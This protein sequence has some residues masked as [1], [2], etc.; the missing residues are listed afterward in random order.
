M[1]F[2]LEYWGWFLSVR[3]HQVS[4]ETWCFCSL[5]NFAFPIDKMLRL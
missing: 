1:R 3:K 5:L 2:L 4:R